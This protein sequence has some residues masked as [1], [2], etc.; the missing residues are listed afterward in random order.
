MIS[1]RMMESAILGLALMALTAGAS[2]QVTSTGDHP[3]CR[4][5]HWLEAML[6]FAEEG[7]RDSYE[8]YIDTGRCIRLREGIDIE[9]R[10]YYGDGRQDRVEFTLR[11][12]PF[13]AHRDAIATPL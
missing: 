2:A 1:H 11:G 3:A 13:F 7:Q 9:V 8:R 4:Q 12:I 6:V 10:S 5:P